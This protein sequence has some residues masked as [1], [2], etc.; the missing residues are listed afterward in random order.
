MSSVPA[1]IT[2]AA[3][4][5]W[6]GRIST[7][8]EI[9]V[10]TGSGAVVRV[11]AE[12][13]IWAAGTGCDQ[14]VGIVGLEIIDADRAAR[15]R[16]TPLALAGR[17]LGDGLIRPARL[18]VL[19]DAKQSLLKL[20]IGLQSRGFHQP[21]DPAVDHDRDFFR[22]RG[23]DADIL[24][25]DEDADV[26]F[27]AEIQQD[28]LDLLDNDRSET[29]G[30]LVHDEQMRV[31]QQRARNRQHLL[32]AAGQLIA[33]IVAPLGEPRKRFVDARESSIGRGLP[34]ASRKCSSTVTE[35]HSR[36]PCGT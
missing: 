2:G 5:R 27:L 30:G 29:L 35:G 33:A 25:D 12:V 24:L 7:A 16:R 28:F 8:G 31:E 9:S 10:A 36:R 4:P 18:T 14:R 21:I 22:N 26:A 11:R 17:R 15:F 13:S 32:L 1:T 6:I 23:R 19:A 3:P 20:A 34:P